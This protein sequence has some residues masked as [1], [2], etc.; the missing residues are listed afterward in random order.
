MSKSILAPGAFALALACPRL[1]RARGHRCRA[2]GNPRADQANEG[3]LRSAYSRA[4]RAAE[5][6]RGATAPQPRRQR[7]PPAPDRLTA[8]AAAACWPRSTRRSRSCCKATTRICRRIPRSTA[9]NNFQ[10]GEEVEPG[11]RGFSLAESE[12]DFL[13]QRRPP[14][15][16]QPHLFALARQLGRSRGSLRSSRPPL[17]YGFAPKFGRFLSGIGYLNDQHQHV[18]D[19]FDAPLAYQAFLGG[20]FKSDGAAAQMGGA[21][22]HVPRVRRRDRRRRRFP[23]SRPQQER[24]RQRAAPTSTP[25]ATSARATAGAR[26]CRTCR[27]GRTIAIARRPTS[28]A[29]TRRHRFSGKSQLA[30]ADFV[31]KWAPNGNAQEHE[32]QAAGRVLLAQGERR[33]HL[34]Q[35]RR[36]RP[37]ADRR[38]LVATRAAGTS[39]A[40]TSSCRTGAS[41]RA[42]TGSIPGTRRLRRQR[43]LT[44][45]T[46]LVQPAALLR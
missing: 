4:R 33:S 23:G 13:R 20:Q 11:R 42:T 28:R 5:G 26:A 43:Q 37:H 18:W 44:S 38:L 14:V 3:I 30:I 6:R 16:R 17:P 10:L 7:Q 21:D 24:H 25:A 32:F 1:R 41:A 36:A 45:R 22:R 27:R 31:W 40:S 34:R 19:F 12:V 15:R 39:T 29:T 9:F 35:R 46:G 2:R 8:Y